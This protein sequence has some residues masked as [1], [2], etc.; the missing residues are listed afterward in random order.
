MVKIVSW[1]LTVVGLGTFGCWIAVLIKQFRAK[2]II[3][4]ILHILTFG[5]TGLIWGWLYLNSHGARKLIFLWT[6]LI[7][8]QIVLI[9]YL[10]AA[11]QLVLVPTSN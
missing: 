3:W 8:L 5:L 11:G 9:A 1:L 2:A 6:A 7:I 4:G 10:I